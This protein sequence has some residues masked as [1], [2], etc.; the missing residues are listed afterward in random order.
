MRKQGT[1]AILTSGCLCTI[2]MELL[3]KIQ[4]SRALQRST[5]RVLTSV[6]VHPRKGCSLV[7]STWKEIFDKTG[8]IGVLVSFPVVW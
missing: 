8:N 2:Q 3:S 5:N 6:Y 1:L 4:W 7:L